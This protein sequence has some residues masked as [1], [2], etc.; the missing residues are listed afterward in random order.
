MDVNALISKLKDRWAEIIRAPTPDKEVAQEILGGQYT[1]NYKKFVEHIIKE[2]HDTK[3]KTKFHI[4]IVGE[5]GNGKTHW[6]YHIESMASRYNIKTKYFSA[7]EIVEKELSLLEYLTYTGIDIEKVTEPTAIIIDEVDELILTGTEVSRIR[8]EFKKGLRKII[9]LPDDT[10]IM[11]VLAVLTR[12]FNEKIFDRDTYSKLFGETVMSVD[13]T[14]PDTYRR[15]SVVPLDSLW[16]QKKPDIE[17]DKRINFLTNILYEYVKY[18]LKRRNEKEELDLHLI[19][20]LFEENLWRAIATMP[21]LCDALNFM[22]YLLKL[23]GDNARPVTVKDVESIESNTLEFNNTLKLI[24][25]LYQRKQTYY[26]LTLRSRMERI[27]ENIAIVASKLFGAQYALAQRIPPAKSGWVKVSSLIKLPNKTI[28]IVVPR[29]DKAFYILDKRKL[30]EKTKKLFEGGFVNEL[31]ILV[32]SLAKSHA[33]RL[34]GDTSLAEL[35][36]SN[37]VRIVSI[38][39]QELNILLSE[40]KYI[41]FGSNRY[42]QANI[43]DE[44]RVLKDVWGKEVTL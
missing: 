27:A 10:P 11:L 14:R 9:D 32:P 43:K 36:S 7:R 23:I 5:R 3:G 20:E 16:K 24:T 13:L 18:E 39:E 37:K 4:I 17:I 6:C 33:M 35:I 1:E 34:I 29:F 40:L 28:A 22:K 19:R 26:E 31:W 15:V 2:F 30:A 41:D 44:L 12:F 21:T 8:E 42:V 38:D 25:E